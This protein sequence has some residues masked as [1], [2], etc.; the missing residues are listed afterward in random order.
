MKNLFLFFLI[1]GGI[2]ACTPKEQKNDELTEA[3]KAEGWQLLFNGHDL[4]GWRNFHGDSCNGWAVEEGCLVS[5]DMH[6]DHSMDI[7]Y[8]KNFANFELRLEWKIVSEGNSGIFFH[9]LEDS[10]DAIYTVAP[11]YQLLDDIGWGGKVK[12][13]QKSGANYAMHAP[14]SNKK[15]KPLGEFNSTRIVVKDSVV[16]HWLNDE[17][18][19]EYKLWDEDWQQRKMNS[20]WKDHPKYGTSPTGFIGLQNHGKKVYLKNIMIKEL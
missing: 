13:E 7:V 12:E 18:V 3:Q 9:A 11:E 4:T 16:Q 5:Q 2:L 6:T 1:A 10:V 17:K 8:P 19:V 20:K 15:L 14:G